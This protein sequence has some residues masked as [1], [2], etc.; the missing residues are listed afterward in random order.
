MFP[1]VIST[2]CSGLSAPIC[3]F[4][5]VLG[6]SSTERLILAGSVCVCVCVCI[7]A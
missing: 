3:W 6:G 1:R 7:T 4:V 5:C 2:D